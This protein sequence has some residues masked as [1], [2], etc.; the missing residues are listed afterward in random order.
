MDQRGS[1]VE[2]IRRSNCKK[3]VRGRE[4]ERKE[5]RRG[6]KENKEKIYK[7]KVFH[8]HE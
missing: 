4:N 6:W 8:R 5:L 1:G 2:R 7:E 3:I